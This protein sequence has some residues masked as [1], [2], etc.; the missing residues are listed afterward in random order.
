MNKTKVLIVDD[1]AL[2]RQV[3]SHILARDPSLTVVGTAADPY[4]AWDKMKT[5]RP[6]VLT[7][8]VEMPRM[9]GLAFLEKLMR[10]HPMP[11]V[12]VSSL[13]E[14]GCETTLRALELGAIDFVTKPILD[15]KD[16]TTALADEIIAKV[17]TA[18]MARVKGRGR[19]PS[20]PPLQAVDPAP[21]LE[22]RALVKSTEQIIAVGAS[23]GGTEALRLFL[24][25][26]PA[27]APGLVIVQHMPEQFTR[28]FAQRLD[29]VCRIRVNEARNGD[30]VLPGHA[31][32]APGNFHIE[33]V[34]SGAN[35]HVQLNMTAPVNHHR[36]S[37][38]VL[39]HSCARELGINAI[40]VIM[41]G[42]GSDGAK[43]LLAM[44]QA[45]ARTVAQ[46]EASCIVFGMPKEAIAVGA[47][48]EIVP[49]SKMSVAVLQLLGRREK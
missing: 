42:M 40:G 18:A 32:V 9:D 47:V 16:G 48:D 25:A 28:A 22:R 46:D 26:L 31:L 34:R 10:L 43:G 41:T 2:I 23:T 36:P 17:K 24:S 37:V 12:M 19:V 14:K 38:D 30:R 33:V 45:G 35:Y 44:R 13:T 20:E 39:F 29:G 4:A 21:R 5:L 49:L 15:I 3:L 7:L 8:D 6:D 1:S 11:V 27:D